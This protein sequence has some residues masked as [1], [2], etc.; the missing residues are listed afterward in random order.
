M[1]KILIP[2]FIALCVSAGVQAEVESNLL[3]NFKFSGDIEIDNDLYNGKQTSQGGRVLFNLESEQQVGENYIAV[4]AQPLLEVDGNLGMDDVYAEF[5]KK[6]DWAVRAGRFEGAGLFSLEDVIFEGHGLYEVNDSR[7][8]G[9]ATGQ[10]MYTKHLGNLTSEVSTMFG[11][12]SDFGMM[13]LEGETEGTTIAVRPVMTYHGTGWD[14]SAGLEYFFSNETAQLHKQDAEVDGRFGYGADFNYY[15]PVGVVNA[16][17]SQLK[18]DGHDNT[19]YGLSTALGQWKAGYTYAANN[20]EN[21]Q[22]TAANTYYGGYTFAEL[23]DI[24]SLS[25]STGAYYSHGELEGGESS[26]TGAR[27]RFNYDF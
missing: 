27:V 7:G 19:S 16:S 5:G 11:R 18:A 9:G 26:D 14:L 12:A 1:K 25:M 13:G 23:M 2:S 17:F 24:E 10:L 4:K 8:R 6:N 20:Y 15:L 21:G 3:N 22:D